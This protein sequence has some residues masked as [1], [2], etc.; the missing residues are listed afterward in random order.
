MT[1][2]SPTAE[3]KV[4]QGRLVLV[5]GKDEL[6]LFEAMISFWSISGLQVLPVGGKDRFRSGAGGRDWQRKKPRR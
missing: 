3:L 1:S 4:S 2:G 5:E 6:N